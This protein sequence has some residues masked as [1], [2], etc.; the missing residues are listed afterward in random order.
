MRGARRSAEKTR[1][2][3][4]KS[5]QPQDPAASIFIKA[6][7]MISSVR[8]G[9]ILNDMRVRFSGEQCVHPF[10]VHVTS[11]TTNVSVLFSPS[12]SV[13]EGVTRIILSSSAIWARLQE[14][15]RELRPFQMIFCAQ[16]VH[17]IHRLCMTSKARDRCGPAT[18]QFRFPNAPPTWSGRLRVS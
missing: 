9:K 12:F 6:A 15:G 10:A 1:L 4:N 7:N 3:T 13:V 17:F 5:R 8:V 2:S 11:K 14:T 16:R 18:L